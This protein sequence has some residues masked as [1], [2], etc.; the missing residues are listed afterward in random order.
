MGERVM[1]QSDGSTDFTEIIEQLRVIADTLDERAMSM[2]REAIEAGAT[3]PSA[4]EKKVV[5]SR[6]AIEKAIAL[7]K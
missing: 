6:R 3:K 2:L 1:S 4:Q 7:L 5:Q